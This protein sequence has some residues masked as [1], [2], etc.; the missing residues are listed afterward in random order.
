MDSKGNEMT[1]FFVSETLHVNCQISGRVWH[2]CDAANL[3]DDYKRIDK[4]GMSESQEYEYKIRPNGGKS[5]FRKNE[6]S[7]FW[8]RVTKNETTG[9]WNKSNSGCGIRIGEREKYHDFS[10]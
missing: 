6:K 5:F 4:N 8:E 3:D 2:E 1:K 7:G 10:F 9:R